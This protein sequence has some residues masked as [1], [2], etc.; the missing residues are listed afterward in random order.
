[1]KTR[2]TSISNSSSISVEL[3]PF[4]SVLACTIGSLILLII[5]VTAQSM[6]NQ[7]VVT[8]LARAEGEAVNAKS[9]HYIECLEGGVIIHPGEEFIG[10]DALTQPNSSLDVFLAKIAE[11]SEQE[12]LIM[13]VRPKGIETFYQVRDLAKDRK[14]D[15]GYE[16]IDEGWKLRFSN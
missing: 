1:M 16:P 2:R 15:F 10:I 8:I 13:A 11:K 12:Y 6:G 5:V 7:R 3:F 9:P 4:L 14:I